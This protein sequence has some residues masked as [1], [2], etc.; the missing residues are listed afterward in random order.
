[1]AITW[2]IT[3]FNSDNKQICLFWE[4]KTITFH[5]M[6]I[7]TE[8]YWHMTFFDYI[9]LFCAWFFLFF[10]F[11]AFTMVP[12]FS[13]TREYWYEHSDNN[14]NGSRSVYSNVPIH[15]RRPKR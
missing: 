1:M 4:V 15:H 12:T 11:W 5:K 6:M 14:K 2:V 7:G 10:T 9:V 8:Y 3:P 13:R